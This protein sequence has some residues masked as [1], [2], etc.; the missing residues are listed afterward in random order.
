MSQRKGKQKEAAKRRAG[1]SIRL[2][3]TVGFWERV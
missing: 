3:L 1:I 2:Q